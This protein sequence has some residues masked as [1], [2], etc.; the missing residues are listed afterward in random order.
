[1]FQSRYLHLSISHNKHL[2]HAYTLTARNAH[3]LTDPL[4]FLKKKKKKK[5]KLNFTKWKL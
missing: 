3:W 2:K 1:M 4:S 5:K